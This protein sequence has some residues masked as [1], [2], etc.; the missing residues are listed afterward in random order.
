M[1]DH[2]RSH[3]RLL[4]GIT[5]ILAFGAVAGC[6]DDGGDDASVLPALTLTLLEAKATRSL[7]QSFFESSPLLALI[8]WERVSLLH[9]LL[10]AFCLA[11]PMQVAR[12]TRR[13][14]LHLG[15]ARALVQAG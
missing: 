15:Q 4:A 11:V 13:F 6:S 1:P 9:L 3:R 10:L 12:Q 5:L 14:G 2:P 7:R 8:F